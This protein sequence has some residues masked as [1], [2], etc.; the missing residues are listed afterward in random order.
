MNST[1]IDMWSLAGTVDTA[2]RAGWS[3]A[4][5]FGS[6]HVHASKPLPSAYVATAKRIRLRPP[7]VANHG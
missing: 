2:A 4:T 6:H 3:T 1:A 5:A 7:E